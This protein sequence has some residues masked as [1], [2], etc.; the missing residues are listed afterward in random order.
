MAQYFGKVIGMDTDQPAI[1]A[2]VDRRA[3]VQASFV[4]GSGLEAPFQD[5][6]FDVVICN[7]IYEHVPDPQ[8]MM[9]QISRILK[10]NGVCF[11]GAGNRFKVMEGHY[12]LPFLSWLPKPL[13]DIYLRI[14]GKGHN[15][16]ERHFSYFGIKRLVRNFQIHDY[17]LD[18]IKAPERFS[19]M[20]T[21]KIIGFLSVLPRWFLALF[22]PLIPNYLFILTRKSGTKET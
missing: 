8:Q 13:A 21:P 12:F 14:T 4:C 22:L 18:V 5:E 6:C 16:E 9:D 7:Q 11:F 10:K 3:K 2:A 1:R 15:Y 17:T 20:D 19:Y